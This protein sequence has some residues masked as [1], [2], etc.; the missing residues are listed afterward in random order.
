ML[1]MSEARAEKDRAEARR[2]AEEN[3]RVSPTM[4]G[5]DSHLGF[6]ANSR[7]AFIHKLESRGFLPLEFKMESMK[8]LNALKLAHF[9]SIELL[10][11]AYSLFFMFYHPLNIVFYDFL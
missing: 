9:L 3:P 5:G 2:I 6:S 1:L 8:C 4:N 11:A 10:S 7:E